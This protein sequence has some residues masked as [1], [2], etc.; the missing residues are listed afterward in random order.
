MKTPTK[1]QANLAIDLAKAIIAGRQI[2]EKL[3]NNKFELLALTSENSTFEGILKLIAE[4]KK[5]RVKPLPRLIPWNYTTWKEKFIDPNFYVVLK[6]SPDI[7]CR[8]GSITK[9]HVYLNI[10]GS[11]TFTYMATYYTGPNGEPLGTYEE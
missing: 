4:G 7:M 3:N 9:S 10:S 8:I 1:A 11:W 2:Q 6:G 5:L